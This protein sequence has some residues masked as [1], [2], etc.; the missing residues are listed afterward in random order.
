VRKC[1]LAVKKHR[2]GAGAVRV[3]TL[4]GFGNFAAKSSVCRF[5][6]LVQLFSLL[7]ILLF[8]IFHKS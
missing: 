1:Q 5:V 7:G 6:S 8:F 2:K 4:F 3:A